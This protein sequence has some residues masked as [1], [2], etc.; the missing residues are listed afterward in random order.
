MQEVK[1]KPVSPLG[2]AL[3][4][5][6][7]LAS[8][9][10]HNRHLLGISLTKPCFASDPVKT[11]IPVIKMKSKKT[12]PASGLGL[13]KALIQAQDFDGRTNSVPNYSVQDS[14]ESPVVE[15]QEV[16]N[17]EEKEES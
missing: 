10:F 11:P 16:F 3:S 6:K 9:P 8:E 17:I 1:E 5:A 13:L 7:P 4:L 14:D 12:A 2:F 15:K